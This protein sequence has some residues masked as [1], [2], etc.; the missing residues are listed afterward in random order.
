MTE[1]D[2]SGC[3][4]SEELARLFDDA[5]A[6]WRTRVPDPDGR[7]Q[8]PR[9]TADRSNPIFVVSSVHDGQEVLL[10]CRATLVDVS[11]DGLGIAFSEPL[12][13][14][15]ALHFAIENGAGER[16]H[17]VASV[18]STTKH[19]G[20]YRIGLIFADTA[21]SL[22][23]G[24]ADDEVPAPPLWGNGWRGVWAWLRYTVGIAVR[25]IVRREAA[26]RELT[27][28]EN[29]REVLFVVDAKLFRYTARL[30]INGRRVVSRSGVLRDRAKNI[31]SK[32]A[33]PTTIRLNG[34]GF[35]ASA[36]MRPNAVTHCSLEACPEPTHPACPTIPHEPGYLDSPLPDAAESFA[37]SPQPALR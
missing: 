32:T 14:G 5:F 22:D 7:R 18:V 27:R 25:T 31:F 26:H 10:N 8:S 20:G 16:S 37:Q 11:A 12:P 6:L 24:L 29:G 2:L 28:H 36:T 1:Q 34:A 9:M 17:G 30:D 19:E 13:V 33:C 4:T 35:S 3:V 15:A 23:I 21:Q